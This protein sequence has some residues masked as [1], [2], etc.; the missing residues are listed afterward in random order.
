[1]NVSGQNIMQI[2]YRASP[3]LFLVLSV[4]HRQGTFCC[5]ITRYE[6]SKNLMR[7]IYEFCHLDNNRVVWSSRWETLLGR[8]KEFI[9]LLRFFP[10]NFDQ[11]SVMKKT[12]IF[13]D[14]YYQPYNDCTRLKLYSSSKGN[15]FLFNMH[16]YKC[17]MIFIK[18]TTHNVLYCKCSMWSISPCLFAIYYNKWDNT[19]NYIYLYTLSC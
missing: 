17:A 12:N 15:S 8:A 5:V 18:K 4:S 14:I 6:V 3:C 10:K 19:N 7:I 1:M 2:C 9:T 13:R 11:D 16:R